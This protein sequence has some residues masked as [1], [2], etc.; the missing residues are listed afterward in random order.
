MGSFSQGLFAAAQRKQE[1]LPGQ[2][3]LKGLSPE[4]FTVGDTCKRR[5]QKLKTKLNE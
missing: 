5:Q 2:E 4:E 1:T 3:N